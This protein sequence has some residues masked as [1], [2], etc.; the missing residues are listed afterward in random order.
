MVNLCKN[1]KAIK[2]E[3][4]ETLSY[5][6]CSMFVVFVNN[7]GLIFLIA[8]TCSHGTTAAIDN[9]VS[10]LNAKVQTFMY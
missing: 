5:I 8:T 1:F 2:A 6:P 7:I 10:L 3:Q 4:T 9:Q